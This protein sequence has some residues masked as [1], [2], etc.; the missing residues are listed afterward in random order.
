MLLVNDK[1]R[2]HFRG[3][4]E[5]W[6]SLNNDDTMTP[7]RWTHFLGVFYDLYNNNNDQQHDGGGWRTI[8]VHFDPVPPSS[9]IFRIPKGQEIAM[10]QDQF[11]SMLKQATV[12]RHGTVRPMMEP[13]KSDQILLWES[14][15]F[16]ECWNVSERLLAS[17][18]VSRK[19]VPTRFYCFDASDGDD[20]FEYYQDLFQPEK[21]L[22]ECWKSVNNNV[23]EVTMFVTHGIEVPPDAKLLELAKYLIYPDHF[24]HIV[25]K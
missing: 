9:K 1:V 23:G 22:M 24:L 5:L 21:T 25:V 4:A 7:L 14:N 6:Y 2:E 8:Q 11:N 10:L 3:G 16:E 17:G 13:A 15:S 18:G 19:N 20:K 12:I